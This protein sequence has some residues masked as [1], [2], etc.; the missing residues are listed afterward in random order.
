VSLW[1]YTFRELARRPGR[2][3]LT[4]LGIAIGVAA[5]VSVSIS[6]DTARRAYRDMFGAVGG[7]AELEV[8]AQ[9]LGPFAAEPLAESLADIEGVEA[10]V[11]LVL[12]RAVLTAGEGG[13]TGVL[14][15]GVDPQKDGAT[16]EYRLENGA[17]LPGL[18]GGTGEGPVRLLLGA[19]LAR[20]AGLESGSATSLVTPAGRVQAVVTGL[21]RPPGLAAFNG[22]AVVVMPQ[23]DAQRLF[24]MAGRVNTLQLVSAEGAA[25]DPLRQAVTDALPAGFTVQTP[26]SRGNLAQA[27]LAS[28]E[29]GLNA[30]SALSLVAGGFIILNAFLMSIGERR[31]QLALLR[32]LG[33]TRRQLTRLLLREAAVLAGAGTILGLLAGLAASYSITRLLGQLLVI[34]LPGLRPSPGPFAAGLVLGPVVALAATYFPARAAGRL[35]PLEGLTG[36]RQAGPAA[37]GRRWPL[38]FGLVLVI[39]SLAGVGAYLAG[40]LPAS[41]SAPLF[42]AFLVGC[43]LLI[44]AVVARL[45][46]LASWLLGPLLGPEGRLAFRHLDRHRTRTSLT[47]GVLFVA[48]VVAVSMGSAML[49]NIRDTQDWYRRTIVGDYFVRGIMPDL[50]T[51]QAVPLP[52]SL[53]TEI[54]ALPGAAR[55]D[56]LRFV[57]GTAQDQQI[58]VLARTF[59]ADEPLPLDLETGEAGA[60]R[61]GLLR[62]EV[63]LGTGLA[64]RTGLGVGD[65]ITLQTR[66][67]PVELPVAGTT[68]EYTTGGLALYLE[69][70]RAKELLDVQGVDVFLIKARPGAAGELGPPLQEMAEREGLL[71]QSL[72]DVKAF[73]DDMM[74]GILGVLWVLVALIFVVASLG[75][76]N[77]LTMNVLEQR[78]ELA[79]LRAVAL[80]RR[81]VGRMVLSQALAIALVSLIPGL[82]VGIVVGFL[83]NRAS[84]VVSGQPA[85]YQVDPAVLVGTFVVA[86][87]IALVAA[88]LPARRAAR[89]PIVQS[90]QYE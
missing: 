58:I 11:P 70:Q 47:V 26:S 87:L 29:S 85:A 66:Q 78:R 37:R 41:T 35:A 59:A 32:A 73:I 54:A 5:V 75:I 40:M 7:R 25:P 44:P 8:V 84:R 34:T 69:W 20:G 33:T 16:R 30:L 62:G 23:A 56:V 79:L 51:N 1:S 38:F 39:L 77:T 3:L 88:Y 74:R 76:V 68:T 72:A 6:A 31:P 67:G 53:Q 17:S 61:S 65:R 19:D 57:P 9:G 27:G 82:G 48:V 71:L 18:L 90:L 4:L 49:G 50:G 52:E 45:S 89:L 86:V 22:G 28:T 63:V 55:V 42:A 43:V 64:Q 15:L 13:R 83:L 2:T 10:V 14:V 60:V 12:E 80:T 46:R 81:Q 24:N 36:E 21:L